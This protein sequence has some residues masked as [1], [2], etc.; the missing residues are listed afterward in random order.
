[1]RFTRVFLRPLLAAL[2]CATPILQAADS[3]P[4]ALPAD[5]QLSLQRAVALIP[6]RNP[7]VGQAGIAVRQAEAD[8]QTAGERPNGSLSLSNAGINTAGHNG[9]G[10]YWDKYYST[11]L[12]FS[13]TFE[14]GHKRRYR[15]NQADASLHAA[16][17]DYANALRL[18]EL[19]V[20]DAYWELKRSEEKLTTAQ[21]LDSIE[22]RSLQAAEARLK[23]GDVPALDVDRIRIEATQAD[24]ALDAAR[25]AHGDAQL[26]LA[27]LLAMNRGHGDLVAADEWPSSRPVDMA[28][29]TVARRA[30]IA[31]AEQRV[32]AAQAELDGAHALRHR[33]IT[34]S[35]QY[36]HA[37][38][39]GPPPIPGN[40]NSLLGFGV[41]IPIF[42]GSDYGGEI[43][44]AHADLDAAEAAR[45]RTRLQAQTDLDQADNDL[46]AAASRAQRY[47]GDLLTRARK[48]AQAAEAA[49]GRGGLGLTDLLDARRSLKAVEDSATDAH[50]DYAEALAAQHAAAASTSTE[51]ATP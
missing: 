23:A 13:Q 35:A 12:S 34:F 3:V 4:P 24:S 25:S 39:P 46:A 49:Y 19:A 37:P 2:T 45:D 22:Q 6:L 14:R 44:R 18:S 40:G 38:A 28:A 42:T 9:D 8:T 20:S 32:V 26:A 15:V 17:S 30:D 31:A 33:D 36:E 11:V 41:S 10:G 21:D 51:S 50:A 43:A 29:K 5:G 16:R 48:A 1:M 47:D 7:D 27:S